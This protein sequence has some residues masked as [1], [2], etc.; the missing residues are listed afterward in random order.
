VVELRQLYLC[1][2]VDMYLM[3]VVSFHFQGCVVGLVVE[4]YRIDLVPPL[5]SSISLFGE[6]VTV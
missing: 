6:V 1:I 3:V 5:A 4:G 2:Y